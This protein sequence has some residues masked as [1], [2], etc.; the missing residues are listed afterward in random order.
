MRNLDSRV[1][2]ILIAN[3]LL[4]HPLVDDHFQRDIP[5]YDY[6]SFQLT[7]D[8][9]SRYRFFFVFSILFL[10]KKIDIFIYLTVLH[11]I[12]SVFYIVEYLNIILRINPRKYEKNFRKRH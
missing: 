1:S 11:L 8:V 3:P 2:G 12:K 5:R 7:L 4:N 9:S 6:Q 10:S